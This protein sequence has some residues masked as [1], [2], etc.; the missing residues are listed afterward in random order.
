[1]SLRSEVADREV[2]SLQSRNHPSDKYVAFGFLF[3]TRRRAGTGTRTRT[4]TALMNITDLSW[5]FHA[6]LGIRD[7]GDLGMVRDEGGR[8]K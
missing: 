4:G 6:C 8:G 2:S 7:S 3:P 1:M 5:T